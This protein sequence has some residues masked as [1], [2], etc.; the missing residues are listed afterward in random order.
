MRRNAKDTLQTE[1]C[2]AIDSISAGSPACFASHARLEAF[3]DPQLCIDANGPLHLPLNDADAKRLIAA[4]HQAPFGKGKHT[5][6][7][8]NVR[9]TWELNP[10]EFKIENPAFEQVINTLVPKAAK[11]LG[12]ANAHAVQAELYKLL[13]YEP[14]AMFK[15]HVEYDPIRAINEPDF[16]SR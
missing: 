3:A 14:G 11:A 13:L 10:S 2:K 16:A 1:I 9:R 4:S 6:V 12:V 15:P 5:V 7:D 8:T